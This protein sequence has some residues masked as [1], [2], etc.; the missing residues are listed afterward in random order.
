MST[1]IQNKPTNFR[2]TAVLLQE[3]RNEKSKSTNLKRCLSDKSN[4]RK[5]LVIIGTILVT[6]GIIAVIVATTER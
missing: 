2:K 4:I 6:I 3:H 1:S 5:I